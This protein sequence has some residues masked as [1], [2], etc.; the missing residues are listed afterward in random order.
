LENLWVASVEISLKKV[1][2]KKE[3]VHKCFIRF[4]ENVFIFH[5]EISIKFKALILI[6]VIEM[7]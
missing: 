1:A 4:I 7:I 5:C 3:I 6:S 2:V